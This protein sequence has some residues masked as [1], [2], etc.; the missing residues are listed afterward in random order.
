MRLAAVNKEP[1]PAKLTADKLNQI[2]C[3]RPLTL[4]FEE[5]DG[6]KRIEHTWNVEVFAASL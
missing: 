1:L 3:S 5:V 4:R 6:G 2:M